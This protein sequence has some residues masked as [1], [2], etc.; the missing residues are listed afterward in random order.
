MNAS[1]LAPSSNKYTSPSAEY[2]WQLQKQDDGSYYMYNSSVNKFLYATTSALQ[3]SD[4]PTKYNISYDNTYSH[5]KIKLS[6]NASYYMH[7]YVSGSSYDFRVSTSGSGNKYRVY[8]YKNAST[9]VYSNYVTTC[10][11]IPTPHWE[12]AEIDNAN[13]AVDCG[14]IS[15]K[16]N[17]SPL[18][19]IEA[20]ISIASLVI[21]A[22]TETTPEPSALT[23]TS[24]IAPIQPVNIEQQRAIAN[25]KDNIL[26]T[27]EMFE[28]L[29]MQVKSFIG[30]HKPF[31]ERRI[32]AIQQD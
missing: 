9:A 24:A 26:F 29:G 21:P 16:S 12:G 1:A 11:E 27:K 31:M 5:W 2:I 25:T 10:V 28:K 13:I 4:N 22:D 30:V 20:I 23:S 32:Y 15:F 6:D 8:L 17:A 7:G 19:S 18:S 3:L 14:A